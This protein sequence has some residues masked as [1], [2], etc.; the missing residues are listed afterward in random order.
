M[1]VGDAG[2]FPVDEWVGNS[3]EQIADEAIEFGIGDEV[4]G[5][6]VAQR[7]TEHAREAEQSGIAAGQA[8]W[9]AISANQFALNAKCGGLKRDE[10]NVLKR[11]AVNSLAITKHAC[12]ALKNRV[13]VQ[14]GLRVEPVEHEIPSAPL[15][16]SSSLR[17]KNGSARDYKVVKG[18][19]AQLPGI[20]Q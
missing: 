17:L 4:R 9:A 10:M 12:D 20:P 16:A 8:I 11:R 18:H 2:D 7:S 14:V 6:L 13:A 15:R 3:A 5:L 19:V 1:I